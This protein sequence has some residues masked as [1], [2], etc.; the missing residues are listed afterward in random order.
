[1]YA[2]DEALPSIGVF[3]FAY[4]CH[5]N[6]FLVFRSLDEPSLSA[7]RSTS[8]MSLIAA[9]LASMLLGIV[10]YVS[11][12]EETDANILNNYDTRDEWANVT[13]IGF[14][15]T[16]MLTYPMEV[17]VVRHC[18]GSLFSLYHIPKKPVLRVSDGTPCDSSPDGMDDPHGNLSLM[19]HIVLTV[20]IWG[21]SVA[22]AMIV[23][24]LGLVLELT[25]GVSATVIGFIMP[26]GLRLA[27]HYSDSESP[28][29]DAAF[30]SEIIPSWILMLFGVFALFA[31]T[32]TS[33]LH[34]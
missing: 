32:I 26:G 27:I 14:A 12:R 10:G 18:I 7:W 6:S 34:A 30:W 31:T 24:D 20:G 16:M 13:R 29:S 21:T 25:G 28:L 23:E 5:H 11:F 3:A 22:I 33:I 17:F 9:F 15:M 8:R 2:G 4:V 1:V 19:W